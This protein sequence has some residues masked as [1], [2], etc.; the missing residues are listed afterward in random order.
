MAGFEQ[1][2]NQLPKLEE[3]V[4]K[5]KAELKA[6]SDALTKGQQELAKQK[7]YLKKYQN[8]A[9]VKEAQMEKELSVKMKQLGVKKKEVEDVALLKAEITRKGLALSTLIKLA[10]EFGHGNK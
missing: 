1:A 2:Q 6:T 7:E 10:K 3:G 5:A 8:E 4:A 9:K